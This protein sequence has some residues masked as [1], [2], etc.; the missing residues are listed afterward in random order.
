MSMLRNIWFPAAV[1]GLVIAGNLLGEA[2][3]HRSFSL[4]YEAADTVLYEK[5]AYKL[6]RK[7]DFADIALSDSILQSLG[8]FTPKQEDDSL[9]LTARDTIHA[10]DSLREI[11]P[12][13]Y[14]YY[15]ALLDSLTHTIVRDSL[16][17]KVKEWWEA[18]DTLHARA[19]SADRFRLDSLY[20]RD[21]ADRARAA[22]LAWYNSL[23]K[24]ERRK[25]D[26]EQKM[27]RKMK[28]MDSLKTLKEE[29]KAV[30]DSIL[31][32][33][34]RILESFAVKDSMQYK[35][36]I[37][38]TLDPDFQKMDPQVID[39]SFNY[40]FYDYAFRRQDVNST[41]LGV[42]GSPVQNYNFFERRDAS[43]VDFYTPYESWSYS[44]S[45][46]P[47]FNTKTPYTE[48]AY[49]GTLLM[50]SDETESD[51]LHIFT[52]QNI[53]PALNFQLL[54]DRWGGGG[55]LDNEETKNKTTSLAINYLGKKYMAHAGIIS[56]KISHEE[57]GGMQDKKWVRDTTLEGREIPV[58]LNKA[59]NTLKKRTVFA[60]QQYRIPF[61]FLKDLG[62]PK[63]TLSAEAEDGQTDTL[64]RNVTTAFIGHSSEWNWYSRA[65]SDSFTPTNSYVDNL[66]NSTYN[67][68][69]S[70][71]A[72][73]FRVTQLDN[74]AFIKLQPWSD[75]ALV[76]RLNV[77]VGDSYNT[78]LDQ[79]DSLKTRSVHKENSLYAY[80]GVEG[81]YR[82]YFDWDAKG[83]F[84]FA[85]E[86]IGDFSLSANARLNLFPFRRA[87]RS[88]LTVFAGFETSLTNPD[89]YRERF[90]SNHLS[91]T[92]NLDKTS[93]SRARAGVDIPWWKLKADV[94][95]GL[96]ANY[97]Y[98]DTKA[99]PRQHTSPISVLSASLRKE[100]VI[101]DFLHLDNQVLMQ[102]SSAPSVLPLPAMA[103]NLKWFA[104]FV[105]QKNQH[106]RNVMVMQI[107]LNGWYN[108][109]WYAPAWNPA[110]G[111][112][113]NQTAALYENGP[114]VD[115]FINIQWKTA[116]IFIRYE[117]ANMGWPL[118]DTDYFTA[119]NY[120]GTQR[121]LKLGIF[122]PFYVMPG[123]SRDPGHHHSSGVPSSKS[124]KGIQSSR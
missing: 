59:S 24:E 78:W 67:Y 120:I 40:H 66:F 17:Q 104:E 84:T 15:V 69:Q 112:F 3:V 9:A 72:D 23:S 34:P 48:L 100:F 121:E 113:H 65:Y 11:D 38:W 56:N 96:L 28:E 42:A 33:T 118:K 98:F 14:K 106:G 46:F 27:N 47:H 87:R 8:I 5:D 123:K 74:K 119:H 101:G 60:D 89:H 111:V 95:Y 63:D 81:N 117:N 18:R 37:T 71:S 103:V 77:G 53:T 110:A 116:C 39:T 29:R 22:F 70:A 91:W 4:D 86:D 75:D 124:L 109:Q 61:S 32:S 31:E 21:S 68:S 108:T 62:A 58:V 49:W 43:K 55:M 20:A 6:N 85:G 13:R 88:P 76:S 92:Q 50:A 90:Y 52:T 36:I 80:A 54:F 122:W 30:R 44:H 25:Y 41:W 26:Y 7:G 12:F 64:D 73:Y 115:A 16:L 93:V 45:T 107:G 97:I 79:G 114:V 94:N 83:R 57:N 51:N 19:D 1:A 82:E 10:P 105:A 99:T 35:R 102:T 2:P